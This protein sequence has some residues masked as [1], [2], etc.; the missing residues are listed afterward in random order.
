MAL[1]RGSGGSAA[2]M[3][4]KVVIEGAERCLLGL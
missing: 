4:W 2:R 1:S 3:L